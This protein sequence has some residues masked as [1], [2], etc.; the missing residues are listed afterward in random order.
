MSQGNTKPFEKIFC[1]FC[2]KGQTQVRRFVAGFAGQTSGQVFI[3]DE[4]I[5][6]SAQI[7]ATGDKEWRDQFIAVLSGLS[8]PPDRA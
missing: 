5:M 3:C 1:S 4:C 8:E 6:L 2:G 7:V